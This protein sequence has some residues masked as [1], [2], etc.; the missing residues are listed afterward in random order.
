MKYNLFMSSVILSHIKKAESKVNT[1]RIP[2]LRMERG[3][4]FTVRCSS[5]TYG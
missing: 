3:R 5:R 1:G 2:C 4:D